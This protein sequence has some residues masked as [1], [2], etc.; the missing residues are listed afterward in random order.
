M[1]DITSLRGALIHFPNFYGSVRLYKVTSLKEIDWYYR[2]VID[3]VMI[4]FDYE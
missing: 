4:R 1:I 3:L 2:Y